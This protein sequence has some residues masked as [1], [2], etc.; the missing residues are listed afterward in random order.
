MDKEQSY[1]W[2]KYRDI[3]EE[4][5]STREKVQDQAIN[6]P[7]LK[8]TNLK[9]EIEGKCR[10]YKEYEEAISQ[11]SSS[12]PILAN[13]KYIIIYGKVC[14]H[15]HYLICIILV[16]E[17]TENWSSHTHTHTRQSVRYVNMKT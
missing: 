5:K 15:H 9:E 8:E 3:K 6:K 7:N 4:T 10:L 1:R 13:N 14:R 17:T 12:Y 11:L 16:I 2:L